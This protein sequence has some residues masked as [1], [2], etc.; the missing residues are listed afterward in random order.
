MAWACVDAAPPVLRAN[1]SAHA[2]PCSAHALTFAGCAVLPSR[3]SD[4][5][6]R[7]RQAHNAKPP[8]ASSRTQA[9]LSQQRAAHDSFQR[10]R[11]AAAQERARH[12]VPL[13][14]GQ[15]VPAAVGTGDSNA[16]YVQSYGCVLLGALC[17][18]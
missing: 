8:L 12:A 4:R 14:P 9:E 18:L 1:A 13:L 2:A 10:R 6:Y 15:P 5:W 11:R 3:E 16:L 7:R 17:A